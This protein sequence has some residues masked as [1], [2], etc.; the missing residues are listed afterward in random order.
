MARRAALRAAAA[1]WRSKETAATF[2]SASR[3]ARRLDASPE[4]TVVADSVE[5]GLLDVVENLPTPGMRA[6]P[7]PARST[8]LEP[9]G[10]E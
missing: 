8:P 2:D 3:R 1:S 9:R 6:H 4:A 10:H 7:A 5:E